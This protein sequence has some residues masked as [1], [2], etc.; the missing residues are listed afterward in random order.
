LGAVI[1]SRVC[2]DPVQTSFHPECLQC[3]N[4]L[5][6]GIILFW[7]VVARL[8]LVGYTMW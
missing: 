4:H 7:V 5:V 8:A 6:S 1:T 3:P 2:K